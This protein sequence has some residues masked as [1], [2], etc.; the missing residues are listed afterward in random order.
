M[1]LSHDW[2]TKGNHERIKALNEVLKGRR[3]ITWFDEEN[4]TVGTN[5]TEVMSRGIDCS[6]YFIAFLTINYMEKVGGSNTKDNC[7]KEFQYAETTKGAAKMIVVVMETELCDT[8]KWSGPVGMNLAGKLYIDFTNDANVETVANQLCSCTK[9]IVFRPAPPPPQVRREL[10]R[11]LTEKIPD[12]TAPIFK[13]D[14]C[15]EKPR[16][17]SSGN[18]NLRENVKFIREQMEYPNLKSHQI[19]DR[20]AMSLDIMMSDSMPIKE[21]AA[22]IVKRIG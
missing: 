19:I 17:R 15:E 14:N 13:T 1:F 3:M 20:A 10:T 18:V 11:K 16:R 21:K 8:T 6:E 12:K 22:L 2:K 5:I 7:K 9:S 4:I